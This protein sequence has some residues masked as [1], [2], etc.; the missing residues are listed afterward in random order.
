MLLERS[1]QGI[2]LRSKLVAKR[3]LSAKRCLKR[4]LPGRAEVSACSVVP[5]KNNTPS[6]GPRGEWRCWLDARAAR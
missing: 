2:A 3:K 5:P 6:G 4:C 1:R